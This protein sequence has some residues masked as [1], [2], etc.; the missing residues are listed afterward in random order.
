R[1]LLLGVP[2]KMATRFHAAA[3]GN[4]GWKMHSG[5]HLVQTRLKVS[6]VLEVV[7]TQFESD[8]R[9]SDPHRQ[10]LHGAQGRTAKAGKD[11]GYGVLR[12]TESLSRCLEMCSTAPAGLLPRTPRFP[13]SKSCRRCARPSRTPA[14]GRLSAQALLILSNRVGGTV[15]ARAVP[16]CADRMGRQDHCWHRNGLNRQTI[17]FLAVKRQADRSNRRILRGT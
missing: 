7:E 4:D 3:G 1:C 13:A 2:A 6:Q 17:E 15:S 12:Q 14:L 11:P 9:S 5:Q 8:R 16:H 10:V